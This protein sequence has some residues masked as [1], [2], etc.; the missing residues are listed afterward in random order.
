MPTHRVQVP[1]D[2]ETLAA[3]QDYSEATAMPLG[4]SCAE[5]L[6]ETA[7]VLREMAKALRMAKSAPAAALRHISE[8]MEQQIAAAKQKQLDLTPKATGQRAYTKRKKTG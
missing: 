2:L 8:E 7:P 5:I 4:R 3:V 1:L 6:K